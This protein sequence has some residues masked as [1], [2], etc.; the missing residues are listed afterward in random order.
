MTKRIKIHAATT[1]IVPIMMEAFSYTVHGPS[2]VVVLPAFAL[3][4]DNCRSVD[5]SQRLSV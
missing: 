4:R 2:Q 3:K 5:M 1:T